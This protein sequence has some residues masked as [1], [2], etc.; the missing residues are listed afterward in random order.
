MMHLHL[1]QLNLMDNMKKTKI[2]EMDW[3]RDMGSR[4]PHP[5]LICS[6]F[7]CTYR[8]YGLIP[9]DLQRGD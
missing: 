6:L 7:C 1:H 5:A 9:S 4:K 8:E 3:N 2:K